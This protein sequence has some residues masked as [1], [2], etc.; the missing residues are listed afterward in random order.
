MRRWRWIARLNP[1]VLLVVV[2]AAFAASARVGGGESYNSGRSSGGSDDLGEA[3][4]GCIFQ[5]VIQ[6]VFD[7]PVVG[8]PLLLICIGAYLYFQHQSAGPATRRVIDQAE[9]E[10]R[11]TTSTSA[12]ER[13]I[14]A[15]KAKDPAFELLAFLDRTNAIFHQV[16]AAWFQRNLE[17]VRR[18]LSDATWQRLACQLR[19]L[20]R[21]GIRDATADFKVLDLQIIGLEQTDFFDTL[22][23]RIKASARDEDVP[24]SFTDEQAIAAAMK[25]APEQFIEV[26]SFV[27]KPGAQTKNEALLQGKCPSCG[28]P[29]SGGAANQ[30]EYCKAIVNSGTFDW[31]LA[32]ITQGSEYGA[33]HQAAEGMARLRQK[34]SGLNLETLEDRASLCFW[35]WIDAQS[36]GD[37]N[38][39]ARVA[40]PP[41]TARLK[42]DLEGL[43][44]QN[45]RKVFLEC[46]VGAVDTRCF[47]QDNG[48]D[49]AHVEIRWSARLG[50]VTE[51]TK[52]GDL[53]SVPNR[54]VFVLERKI[55]ATTPTGNGMASFRC[56]NCGASLTDNGLVTCEFCGTALATGEKDWVLHEAMTWEAWLANGYQRASTVQA[57][58]LGD[59][60]PSRE[61]R[62]RLLYV[63]AAM[64][65]ADGVV[66]QRE[67][68]LLKMCST[69]WGV[70]WA[71]VEMALNAGPQ[72]FDRLVKQGSTEA[73]QFLRELVQMALVD[74]K[75]DRKERQLLEAAAQHLGV[76]QALPGMIG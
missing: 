43:K 42:D 53:P 76:A 7:H 30:C 28:A 64:A 26:W 65:K 39:L 59:R 72:L 52:P 48:F 16:Q 2:L 14:G 15:L 3:I 25:K 29:F 6:L 5:I 67:R 34:D 8:I 46:A 62:E 37:S 18:Y 35:K 24:S 68:Q 9:A 66:D 44:A 69:R 49:L 10:R 31:V 21:Q 55:G 57:P 71:N 61:E 36:S 73:E 60:I 54:W 11:T 23:I 47:T 75:I 13:W 58:R 40:S 74:G 45:R 51:G 70:P 63:M 17:P 56:P 19:L 27:R 32:E 12:V 1:V 20:D 33:S 41:F 22:H 4:F 50:L 38:Q